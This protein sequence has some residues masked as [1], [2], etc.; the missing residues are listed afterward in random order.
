MSSKIS[1]PVTA[2]A[3]YGGYKLFFLGLGFVN[4]AFSKKG[5]RASLQEMWAKANANVAKELELR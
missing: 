5:L 2:L 3:I 1:L 4:A